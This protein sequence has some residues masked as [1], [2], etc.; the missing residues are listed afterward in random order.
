[1]A[2]T[3]APALA[4]SGAD[5]IQ[6]WAP[7]H[8]HACELAERVGAGAPELLADIAR[9]ADFYIVA[10][11]DA[12]VAEVA[13]KMPCVGGIVAHTSGSVPM[14]ALLQAS[15]RVG[16]LYPLQ[17]FSKGREVDVS[18]VPFFTEANDGN[19]LSRIDA[20][21][22]SMSSSVHH[23]DSHTRPLLHVA[24]V[25]GCN[26]SNYLLG[27]AAE[28][29]SRGGY[30]LDV[31]RPLLRE[32]VAKAF[33]TTPLEAQTGPAVR[34]DLATIERH[35]AMLPADQAAIYRMISQAIID[36]HKHE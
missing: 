25:L 26:F 27:C 36:I 12:A 4:K 5:V 22:A 17:T 3:L 28:V 24:G 1:M 20:L 13:E 34:G 2:S 10:V 16:V 11:R 19:T 30:S 6:V 9:D 29:L 32:T 18:V 14:D 15:A 35:C 31:L 23:A 21:A 33:D 8:S 7:T